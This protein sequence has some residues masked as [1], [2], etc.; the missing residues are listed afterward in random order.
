M[1]KNRILKI[2]IFKE[3]WCKEYCHRKY[4]QNKKRKDW[5]G[6]HFHKK[7]FNFKEI[8]MSI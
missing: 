5:F 2:E 3:T 7:T 1:K 6:N 8:H 4:N